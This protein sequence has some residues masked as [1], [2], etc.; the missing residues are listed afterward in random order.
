LGPDAGRADGRPDWLELA[1]DPQATIEA[2][3]AATATGPITL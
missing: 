3:I 1:D 2:A